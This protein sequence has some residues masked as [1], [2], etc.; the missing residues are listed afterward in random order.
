MTAAAA[1]T[2]PE[3]APP[4]RTIQI[5]GGRRRRYTA[6][7]R[8]PTTWEGMSAEDARAFGDAVTLALLDAFGAPART[9][10]AD[11]DG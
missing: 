11:A 1:D 7:L 8:I 6:T 4:K 9:A 2:T 5:R 10:R 3:P